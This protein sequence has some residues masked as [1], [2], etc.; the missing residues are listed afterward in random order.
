[1]G[2]IDEYLNESSKEKEIKEML[3]A[4]KKAFDE[5]PSTVAHNATVKRLLESWGDA[6]RTRI[7]EARDKHDREAQPRKLTESEKKVNR[8][9]IAKRKEEEFNAMPQEYKDA[10][11][12]FE[13]LDD[14]LKRRF[15]LSS[16]CG[17]AYGDIPPHENPKTTP[18]D[19]SQLQDILV[20]DVI[21]F[22]NARGLQEV[23]TVS[24]HI[25]GLGNSLKEG[26]WTP[27]SDSSI[28]FEGKTD[29]ELSRRT[30]IGDCM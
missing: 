12:A 22:L 13:K 5:L 19:I 8:E 15:L 18:N 2:W 4:E 14:G 21:D 23:D 10:V 30:F 6:Y 26:R 20:Q 11:N 27:S 1:M 16:H 25:D 7:R 24:F 9:L 17:R 28:R 29:E 3:D